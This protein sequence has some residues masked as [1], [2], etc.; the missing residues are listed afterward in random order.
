MNA[1]TA[2]ASMT[3]LIGP[4]SLIIGTGLAT[5]AIVTLRAERDHYAALAARPTPTA[6]VTQIVATPAP[7]PTPRATTTIVAARRV[8]LRP[9][10]QPPSQHG[11]RAI[12]GGMAAEQAPSTPPTRPQPACAGRIAAVQLPLGVLGDCLIILG[13]AR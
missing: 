12:D 10:A 7:Q 3:A 4:A 6:T 8:A 11:P 9:Q 2:A 13:G 5:Q 1:R